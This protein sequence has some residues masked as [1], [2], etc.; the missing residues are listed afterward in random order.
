MTTVAHDSSGNGRDGEYVVNG[1]YVPRA[2]PGLVSGDKAVNFDYNFTAV[3]I[4]TSD[5]DWETDFTIETWIQN[6]TGSFPALGNGGNQEQILFSALPDL[7]TADL[8]HVIEMLLRIEGT[9]RKLQ[10][11]S[12]N[13]PYW[14]GS[15]GTVDNVIPDDNDP[16]HVAVTYAFRGIPVSPPNSPTGD[17]VFYVD[18][19]PVSLCSDPNCT[20]ADVN[21]VFHTDPLF[22]WGIG[23]NNGGY[24]TGVCELV[25]DEFALYPTAL[26]AG[27]IAAHYA[28]RTSFAGY[29][30]AVLADN[31]GN[32]YHLN[33]GVYEPRSGWFVGSTGMSS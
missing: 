22:S 24:G 8:T 2:F 29:T 15:Y 19:S 27:Q 12:G 20:G 26:T 6:P 16:H 30:A 33:E 4:D 25:L 17:V 21:A 10:L 7:A 3:S 13:P 18:G 31:P 5:V 14:V 11:V 32:Y 1:G 23:S 28:A 9:A